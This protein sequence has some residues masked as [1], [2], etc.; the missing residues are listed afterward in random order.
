VSPSVVRLVVAYLAHEGRW[1]NTAARELRRWAL[2]SLSAKVQTLNKQE[3]HHSVAVP[4]Q[5]QENGTAI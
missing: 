3:N 2:S 4:A 1:R 5:E